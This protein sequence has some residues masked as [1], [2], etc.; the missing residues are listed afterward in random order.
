MITSAENERAR[1]LGGKSKDARYSPPVSPVREHKKNA[2][3]NKMPKGKP[4]D[5]P[6]AMPVITDMTSLQ[7]RRYDSPTAYHK[8]MS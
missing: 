2:S 1:I 3:T 5:P 8:K 6:P 7:H 4:I